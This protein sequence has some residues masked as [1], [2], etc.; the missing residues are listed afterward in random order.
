MT[1]S[2]IDI[3]AA[4]RVEIKNTIIT[5]GATG[6]TNGAIADSGT[7]TQLDIHDCLL[8]NFKT[9]TETLKLSN[10]STG[11]VADT[12]CAGRHATIA[13]TIDTGTGADFFEVYV[14]DSAA[15]NGLLIPTVD[16]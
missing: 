6:Y 14:V 9:N 12:F 16:A 8:L 11:T 7:A 10:N 2:G 5:G 3:G 1:G 13:S 15:L 4:S